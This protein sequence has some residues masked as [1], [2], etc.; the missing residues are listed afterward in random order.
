MKAN[1]SA[2]KGGPASIRWMYAGAVFNLLLKLELAAT[3]PDRP[4]LGTWVLKA[5]W[6]NRT[7]RLAFIWALDQ[8]IALT[9]SGQFF[10]AI[11]ASPPVT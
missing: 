7:G 9:G 11:S 10:L 8:T 3:R 6:Q 4:E 5:A 2:C 1:S